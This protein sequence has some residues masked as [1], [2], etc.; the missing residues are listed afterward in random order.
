RQVHGGIQHHLGFLLR[1]FDQLRRD[2]LRRRRFGAS[3]RR[4]HGSERE[5]GRAFQNVASGNFFLI[6]RV[7][8]SASGYRLSAR[9]RSGGRKSQTSLPFATA[10]SVDVTMRNVVPSDVSTI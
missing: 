4:E 10:V 1:R 3:R 7:L 9:Q 2:R 6:H 5:R 8:L